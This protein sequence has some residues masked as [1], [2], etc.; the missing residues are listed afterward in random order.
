MIYKAIKGLSDKVSSLCLGTMNLGVS[1]DLAGSFAVLDGFRE[2]GGNF[3]DTARLYGYPDGV[4]YG[5]S[6]KVIGRWMKERGCRDQMIVATK[7]GHPPLEDM[8]HGRLDRASLQS[9]LEGS[10]K[11]LG[12][13]RIDLYWLH[14]DDPKLPVEEILYTLN[15]FI[16][17]GKIGAIGASNWLPNRLEQAERAAAREG[18]TGFCADQPMWSLARDEDRQD[19]AEKRLVQMDGALYA[20]HQETGLACAPFTSQAKGFYAKLDQGGEE[21]LSDKA[22]R[23]Y[24]TRHNLEL[25]PALKALCQQ[26]GIS[27]A[28]G[29]LAY[30]TNQPFPTF[31]IAGV[32]R[33]AHLEDLRQAADASLPGEE[34]APLIQAAGLGEP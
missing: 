15:Q 7:G 9:D 22:R 18:M 5:A 26:A 20:Y 4:G 13:E 28:A 14:R 11:D 32:S 8:G 12:V 33:M 3:L 19:L 10:L 23:R 16:K 24:L 31:P 1:L 34:W 25:Y 27:V 29:A 2:M 17:E 30:L 6:E 21:A